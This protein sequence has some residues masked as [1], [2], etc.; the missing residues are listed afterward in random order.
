LAKLLLKSHGCHAVLLFE[1]AA[2]SGRAAVAEIVSNNPK[3]RVARGEQ[4]YRP[5][6]PHQLKPVVGAIPKEARNSRTKVRSLTP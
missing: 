5:M 2:K 1:R 6:V 4:F 3:G